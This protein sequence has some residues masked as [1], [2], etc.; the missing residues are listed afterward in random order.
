MCACASVNGTFGTTPCNTALLVGC[1]LVNSQAGITENRCTY[2]TSMDEVVPRRDGRQLREHLLRDLEHDAVVRSRAPY[3]A[4]TSARPGSRPPWSCPRR[5]EVEWSRAVVVTLVDRTTRVPRPIN[6]CLLVVGARSVAR[7]GRVP[8]LDPAR[9][10]VM[11]SRSLARWDR[12]CRAKWVD[13]TRARRRSFA[14]RTWTCGARASNR[15]VLGPRAEAS[16]G[17]VLRG[18]TR[19]SRIRTHRPHL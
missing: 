16:E 2:T 5:P 11:R 15:R 1:C 18:E 19:L 7:G 12:A 9:L 10:P 4:S 17:A 6:P 3:V 14:C 8:S 13:P